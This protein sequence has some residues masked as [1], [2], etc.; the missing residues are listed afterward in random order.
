VLLE[1][2]YNTR[3]VELVL[4]TIASVGEAGCVEKA[5]LGKTLCILAM[6]IAPH[7]HLPIPR[8]CS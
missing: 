3:F 1:L 7:Q 4:L 5:D 2:S 6:F 8:S